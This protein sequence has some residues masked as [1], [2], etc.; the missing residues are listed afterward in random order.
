MRQTVIKVQVSSM[1]M[2]KPVK[3]VRR[4]RPNVEIPLGPNLSKSRP[5]TGLMMPI[6][7][8]P[9]SMTRPDSIAVN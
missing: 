8:E 7:S 6:S 1:N 2:K 4:A 5:V 3:T 9:G